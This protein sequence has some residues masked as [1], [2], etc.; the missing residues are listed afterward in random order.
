MR[1]IRR[2]VVILDLGNFG[3]Q[4]KCFGEEALVRRD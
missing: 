4:W 1:R 2:V 3:T